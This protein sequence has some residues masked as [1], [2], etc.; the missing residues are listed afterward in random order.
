[1]NQQP[2][3]YSILI[4]RLP[5][6]AI[7]SFFRP[8]FGRLPLE[9]RSFSNVSTRQRKDLYQI[10]DVA[11]TASHEEIKKA[12]YTLAKKYHPDV[13]GVNDNATFAQKYME[14]RE[15][16]DILCD[17]EK[18]NE[19]DR[20]LETLQIRRKRII[21]ARYKVYPFVNRK[22]TGD[23]TQKNRRIMPSL[24]SLSNAFVSP[25]QWRR[26]F[27]NPT[28]D[29]QRKEKEANIFKGP[30]DDRADKQAGQRKEMPVRSTEAHRAL[31][32]LEAYH[33]LLTQPGDAE[34]RF[35]IER[36]IGIFKANLFQ[37]LLDIQEFYD[38]TLLNERVSL[39]LKAVETR[40]LAERWEQNPPFGGGP[41]TFAPSAF[42]RPVFPAT[43][44]ATPY[45]NG[46]S[47]GETKSTTQSSH[48]YSYQEQSKE[49]TKDGWHTQEYRTQT[50]D[51]PGGFQTETVTNNGLI[52]ERGNE[53]DV[54]DVVL[55]K[56][57]LGLG[58]SIS[59]GND[60]NSGPYIR[61]TDIAHGG[62]VARDGRIRV[63]DV[64]LK[65]N[66]TDTVDVPHQVA[67]NA[68]KSAGSVVRL[69]VKRPRAPQ[70][71]VNAFRSPSVEPLSRVSPPESFS[72]GPPPPV[73]THQQSYGGNEAIKEL[74]QMP[75]VRRMDL[76]KMGADG[77]HKGLGFSIAGGAGNQHYPG[78]DGLFV[79]RVI[80]GTPAYYDG[81][82]Q[83][84]DQLL[85]VDN[86]IFKNVTHE[87][88]V[89]TLKN[90]GERVALLYLK[91]PHPD[92]ESIGGRMEDNT[93]DMTGGA[94]LG[95]SHPHLAYGQGLG[96]EPRLV[97]L[98]K[99]DTGLGF[100][101]VGGEDGEKV[102]ISGV[103][104]GGA[105]DLSGNVRK[106]DVL[107]RVNDVDLQN[108]THA[109]AAQTLKAVP[110]YSEVLLVLQYLPQEYQR[111]EDKVERARA[112]MIQHQQN[113]PLS[114]NLPSAAI[115]PQQE[116]P[117][118]R[119]G[120]GDAAPVHCLS[121][122]RVA[123][124][125][126]EGPEGIIPS[127]K[128]VE[129]REKQRRKQVNFNAGSQS[130]GRN[131]SMSAGG[132]GI[133]GGLE[134]RR[135]SRSQLSFSRKFPFV[136]STEKLNEYA[137]DGGETG[138]VAEEP[139]HAYATVELRTINYVRP[140]I[141]LGALK[142]RVNDE[143]VS[144]HPDRFSSCVPHTSRPPRD[145]EVHGRNYYF[146]SKAEMERDVKS[147]LFIEAG[148]FQNNLYG[149]SIAAVMEVA[150]S[151][152]HCI[153]D[154]SGN[155][156]RRLQNTAHIYPISIF[157]KPLNYHQLQEWDTS[158]NEEDA[159]K[160][161][162]RCQR[163]EQNFG[164]LFTG[165]VTGHS[166]DDVFARVLHTISEQSRPEVWVPTNELLP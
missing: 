85:A 39:D 135:G 3:F 122:R 14:I 34:L 88:A 112:E 134:G 51:G 78:D 20:R 136:K 16:Y 127:K 109:Q 59:G 48:S 83:K 149:T 123:E 80:E 107:L 91:N 131:V 116:V 102:F 72:F 61:V 129:K 44:T 5:N 152:R 29:A 67:V 150:E 54:E 56:N 132:Y 66:N 94:S 97:R 110:N 124:N 33:A 160:Q 43:T 140:V 95:G 79:T 52:D 159:M 155:A 89:N 4:R 108:A 68:L 57:Q 35:A 10:L 105:A 25:H 92:M 104:P 121:I 40:K 154:V 141:V 142:D 74:E 147:N 166:P 158:L 30:I 17:E 99:L 148:Q 151:G 81:R 82:L 1:M 42:E 69:L 21:A 161:F 144:R 119:R 93:F 49:L 2:L 11:P 86:T 115:P 73:P 128:R 71:N 106:G 12:Y 156:I 125:G 96:T 22:E 41:R 37:A 65:V 23:E 90:T 60:H 164:D 46:F 162:E 13:S 137:S 9:G 75:G 165:M 163:Q 8:S 103:F 145:G 77:R 27:Q 36:V 55:E 139:I 98:R 7:P 76:I 120:H 45:T 117:P 6:F 100:N 64:I 28:E 133:G 113:P 19:H 111:F 153:L 87:F 53:W 138:A 38:N 84:G 18:R 26:P 126:D 101:I 130:L 50:L 143:L 24:A 62:G 118:S 157:V 32:Q 114:L 146:V 70:G 58:F 63:G 47:G 31:E 15:A